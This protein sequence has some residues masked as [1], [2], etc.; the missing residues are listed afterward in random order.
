MFVQLGRTVYCV[1][2]GGGSPQLFVSTALVKE[3]RA[4]LVAT[5]VVHVGRCSISTHVPVLANSIDWQ[6]IRHPRHA[7]DTLASQHGGSIF[8]Y[9]LLVLQA[10]L[11]IFHCSLGVVLHG[12]LSPPYGRLKVCSWLYQD[13]Q[14]WDRSDLP[15]CLDCH[16][17]K[18]S[19]V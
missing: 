4:Q 1:L 3:G 2:W 9:F 18:A 5:F 7:A 10:W 12:T 14:A 11:A 15:V 19:S 8:L 13:R 6:A 16:Q 17:A